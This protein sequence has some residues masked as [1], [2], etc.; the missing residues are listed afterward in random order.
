[1]SIYFDKAK[2]RWRFQ[3]DVLREGRRARASKLLPAV[4]GRSE[5]EE[6]DK[7]ETGRLYGVIS[8]TQRPRARV[9]E[10]LALWITHRAP[11]LKNG[12]K[13]VQELAKLLPYT[14]GRFCDE[15]PEIAQTYTT[16]MMGKLSPATIRNRLAYLKSALRYAYKQHRVCEHDPTD[17]MV[18]P[19]VNNERQVYI[20]PNDLPK[21]TQYLPDDTA[22]LI[23]ICLYTGLRW[24]SEVKTLR[25]SSIIKQ[26]RAAWLQVTNTKNGQPHMIP[27]HPEIRRDIM[28][29]PFSRS[30]ADYA[31]EFRKARAKA[32]L[33]HVR[34]HDLRHSLASAMI[35]SG[36]TL[37][38][39]GRALNH[40]AVQSTRRYS[41]LYPEA[42]SRA[43]M[44]V[45]GIGRNP[46]TTKSK[47]KAG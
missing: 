12:K 28:R 46:P 6:Y 43:V 16:A 27:V 31:K 36:S 23:R 1:M 19:A 10:A 40:K 35:S 29:I 14:E 41:H 18:M 33:D 47:K 22:A 39:V 11:V 21:I 9:S 15:A 13:A 32:G 5:A 8:G 20:R 37:A 38:E 34:M 25:P 17:R 44:R 2:K 3:F 7:Q 26:G 45:P 42:M 24:I 4:W 30:Q